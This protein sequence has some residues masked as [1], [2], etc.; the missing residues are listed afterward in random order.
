MACKPHTAC[1]VL[2]CNVFPR[3]SSPQA[4]SD[5]RSPPKSEMR[6]PGSAPRSSP[7]TGDYTNRLGL[8]AALRKKLGSGHMSRGL[9]LSGARHSGLRS[10]AIAEEQPDGISEKDADGK[11]ASETGTGQDKA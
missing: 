6:A 8:A 4:C 7:K 9:R 2:T 11:R 5:C 1:I 10:E 3:Q